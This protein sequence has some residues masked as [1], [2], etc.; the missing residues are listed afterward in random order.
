VTLTGAPLSGATSFLNMTVPDRSLGGPYFNG[1]YLGGWHVVSPGY[2]DT[3]RIPV[4]AG[5]VFGDREVSTTAPVVVINQRMARQF[6][7]TESPI[8]HD[9]L[10]GEGAGPEFEE[11]TPRQIIGVVGDVRHVGL[12]WEARPTACSAIPPT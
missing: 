8:G 6:W 5:R 10:I 2:F 9:V 3:L 11:T 1:G 4:V 7:P 12:E